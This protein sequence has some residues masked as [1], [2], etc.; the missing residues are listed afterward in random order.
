MYTKPGSSNTNYNTWAI[1][2]TRCI[3]YSAE[4]FFANTK[5]G[6]SFMATVVHYEV[7]LLVHQLLGWNEKLVYQ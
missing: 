4:K 1:C 6:N 3:V 7:Y 2:I 5:T